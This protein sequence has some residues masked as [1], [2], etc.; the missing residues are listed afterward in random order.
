MAS[1]S[2][3]RV[4]GTDDIVVPYHQPAQINVAQAIME[5]LQS[6]K[7]Q[8]AFAGVKQC[9][10]YNIALHT[11]NAGCT[12]LPRQLQ[13]EYL[14]RQGIATCAKPEPCYTIGMYS[15]TYEQRFVQPHLSW[16]FVPMRGGLVGGESAAICG[17]RT[18][19]TQAHELV[20]RVDYHY[21]LCASCE[22]AGSVCQ[23]ANQALS[24]EWVTIQRR[25]FNA[26]PRSFNRGDG[27]CGR[28]VVATDDS[29]HTSALQQAHVGIWISAHAV[30]SRIVVGGLMLGCI[31]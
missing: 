13:L 20:Q 11:R 26:S 24:N 28:P 4:P 6:S 31:V 2:F 30:R 5:E 19:E 21:G 7:R 3:L 25:S 16:S 8:D 18:P 23:Q 12:L 10:A 17:R 1:N 22:R 15:F 14:Q 27:L 29:E 9:S